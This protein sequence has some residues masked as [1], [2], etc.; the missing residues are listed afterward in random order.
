MLKIK[1]THEDGK[2]FDIILWRTNKN[3]IFF[4]VIDH[5]GSSYNYIGKPDSYKNCVAAMM[6]MALAHP[7]GLAQNEKL[8]IQNAYLEQACK[9]IRTLEEKQA[10][11]KENQHYLS[12]SN[13]SRK[14]KG[15]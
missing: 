1:E 3:R 7:P 5:K 6:E 12:S 11:I 8:E 9:I 4:E 2:W 14:G 10:R 15:K 13:Q